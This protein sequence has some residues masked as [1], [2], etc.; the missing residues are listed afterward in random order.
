M[1]QGLCMSNEVTVIPSGEL[2]ET[3]T[4]Y[5]YVTDLSQDPILKTVHLTI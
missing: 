4:K 1:L 3:G 2:K 5:L